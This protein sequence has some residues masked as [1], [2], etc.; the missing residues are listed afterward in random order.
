ME[1]DLGTQSVYSA[2]AQR[3]GVCSTT[4][5]GSTTVFVAG[6]ID[7][8]TSPQLGTMFAAV[9]SHHGPRTKIDLS[10]VSFCDCAGLNVLLQA[11]AQATDAGTRFSLTGPVP[12]AVDRLFHAT[13]TSA[14]LP[15][16]PAA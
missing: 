8:Q 14:V 4:T 12:P 2:P 10:Q 1:E 3:F 5:G 6:E 11:R 7:F 16:T 13:G 15:V 9:L